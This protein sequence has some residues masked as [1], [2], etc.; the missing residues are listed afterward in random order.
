MEMIQMKFTG[1]VT[2]ETDR[3]ILRRLTADDACDM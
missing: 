1:T 3:L 2:L